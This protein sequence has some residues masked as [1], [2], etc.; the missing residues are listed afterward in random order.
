MV[1]LGP[2]FPPWQGRRAVDL[3]QD[4]ENEMMKFTN[5][6]KALRKVGFQVD[7][8]GR[9]LRATRVGFRFGIAIQRNGGG[10]E[11]AA[12]I[13]TFPLVDPDHPITDYYPGTYWPSLRQAIEAVLR[14]PVKEPVTA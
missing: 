8:N 6:I 7:E 2:R 12:T 10:S 13:K 1:I 3:E 4:K 11:N 14:C 5:A 9:Y